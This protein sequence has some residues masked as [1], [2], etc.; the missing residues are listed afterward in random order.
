MSTLRVEVPRKLKPLLAPKRYKGAYGGRGGAKSHSI[1]KRLLTDV[2]SRFSPCG[3]VAGTQAKNEAARLLYE[4][5]GMGVV[6]RQSTWHKI[7]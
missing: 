2:M 7:P 5:L 3:L 1:A 6:R 4:G